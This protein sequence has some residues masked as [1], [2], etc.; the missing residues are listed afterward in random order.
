MKRWGTLVLLAALSGCYNYGYES[1]GRQFWWG[2]SPSRDI[3]LVRQGKTARARREAIV[4]LARHRKALLVPGERQ[5]AGLDALRQ[6]SS[7]LHEPN[8][9]VRA[10]AVAALG[11]AGGVDD[12]PLLAR[13]LRGDPGLGQD[14]DPSV[15]VRRE[16]ARAL[17]RLGV[18]R[19]I[20]ALAEALHGDDDAETR[21]E[22][23]D[24]IA[25]LGTR[26][27]MAPL[28]RGM[29]DL[30]DAVVFACHRG[31]VR[32]TGQ[33]LPPSAS[34]WERWWEANKSRPLPTEGPAD[35]KP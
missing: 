2:L 1:Q 6:A 7:L 14:A 9:V 34:P 15:A 22:C 29:S 20:G 24:A 17:G 35:G 27:A 21:A 33:D 18:P 30:E 32:T 12:A 16:A 19:H 31:L 28:L 10:T 5:R 8:P 11:R 4:R 23:A 25:A 3:K 13:V 26:A